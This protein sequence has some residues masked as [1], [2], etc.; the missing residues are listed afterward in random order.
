[1]KYAIISRE[2]GSIP[3]SRA[4]ELLG[5][6]RQGFYEQQNRS[7]MRANQ[8]KALRPIIQNIFFESNRIY[9]SRKILAELRTRG[10][11]VSRKRVV[12][13][14]QKNGL[15]PVAFKRT[16]RTT[17]SDP[18]ATPFPNLLQQDFK[19]A[20]PDKTWVTD[21]TYIPTDEGWLYLCAFI[22]LF[23]RRVVGWAVRS[24][25][26]RNLAIE[27]L[28]KAVALRRPARGII[29]HSDRGC[30]Y[31]SSDFRNAV[32]NMGGI[33]SMSRPGVPYDNACAETF[34]KSIKTER[35]N[36]LHFHTREEA[37]RAVCSYMLFY[38]RFRTHQALGY[39]TPVAFEEIY[40]A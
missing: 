9:G 6:R 36:R 14:M 26:D 35:L 18:R 13:L 2:A 22:D 8:E 19:V 25:I 31:T 21:F 34:F 23:S 39:M 1:M 11:R 32:L 4:C 17:V 40:S 24:T 16:V 27:A 30:Q 20:L 15:V 10:W 33:Q 7:F 5:V 38:N 28:Q 29:I 3:I 37:L 12:S